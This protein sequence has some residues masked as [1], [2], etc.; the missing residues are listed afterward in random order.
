MD[1]KPNSPNRGLIIIKVEKQKKEFQIATTHF[2][3]SRNGDSNKTQL[4]SLDRMLSLLDL[5]NI[6][7][8]GD[9]NAPRGR[10]TWIILSSKLNDN[11]PE[12][13][14]TTIDANIHRAGDLHL[15]VDGL[16][17]SNNYKASDVRVVSGVS[18]HC[19]IAANISLIE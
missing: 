6:V 1:G 4:K 2:T 14:K 10:K 15:V 8:C 5:N 12:N 3:W 9:F 11:I 19:A 16:F 13:I 17:T 7:L 18:D